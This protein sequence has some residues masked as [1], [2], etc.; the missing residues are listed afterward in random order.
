MAAPG[1]PARA[2]LGTLVQ[3]LDRAAPTELVDTCG[4]WL[5]RCVEASG[6]E[7][8]L[9]DYSETF[10]VPVSEADLSDER[11]C[12]VDSGPAGVVYRTQRRVRV[13]LPGSPPGQAGSVR[14]YLP[15]SMRAERLGV[16]VVT[17]PGAS[18][19]PI[20]DEVLQEVAL[21]LAYVLG[22]TERYT[23]QFERLR[24]RHDLVLAAEIQWQLLPVLAYQ[25]PWLSIAGAL[26]PA[27]DIGGDTFDYAVGATH[28]TVTI[29]D[30]VGH[31]LRAALLASLAVSAMRNSRRRGEPIEAQAAAANTHL[32]EQFP[33]ASFVTGLLMQ[34][35]IATG[36]ATVIN[37]GHPPPLLLRSGATCSLLLSPEIPLGLDLTIRYRPQ[38]IKFAPGDRLLMLT[39]G[40]TE[41]HRLG[42]PGFGME[43]T[44]EALVR[45]AQLPP[46]EFVR[47]LTRT[48]LDYRGGELSDDA[49]AVCLDW[50][51]TPALTS[52]SG[53]S[54]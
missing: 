4:Q 16:L 54:G 7:L 12:R 36:V 15:V 38:R 52:Q 39:D 11:E 18:A 19:E 5:S 35:E 10:L 44:T 25:L 49:T 3:E 41:A 45:Y 13:E 40:V 37:A 30:A 29:T 21:V 24:R 34:I 2:L 33:G 20:V 32:A 48:V 22:M 1:K 28:L 27:Y 47:R 14:V 31:G 46:A 43:R 50:H 53:R 23:D 8:L 9:A 42:G 26:E 17:L 6:C 51:P